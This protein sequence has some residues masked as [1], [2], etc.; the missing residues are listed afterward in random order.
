[1]SP[2]P[3][4]LVSPVTIAVP[5]SAQAVLIDSLIRSRSARGKPSSIITAQVSAAIS[6]API[7]DRSFTVPDT[8]R[9]PISPPGKNGGLTTYESVVITSH[10]SP[11]RNAAPSSIAASPMPPSTGAFASPTNT[12]WISSRIARPPAPCLSITFAS[13]AILNALMIAQVELPAVLMPDPAGALAADHARANGIIG[14][15][16]LAEQPTG[17]RRGDARHD[18]AADAALCEARRRIVPETAHV[19]FESPAR[20]E[21]RPFIAQAQVAVG[22]VRD[23]APSPA[24]RP[25]HLPQHLLRAAV[26]FTRDA[27][28]IHVRNFGP[29]V[30]D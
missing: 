5:A 13:G 29:A 14:H 28:R 4:T 22:N 1:M 12:C 10:S 21:A 8:A 6:V 20:V 25:K 7:I 3:I 16:F 23:S 18:V 15:A 24:H 17:R 9:R 19:D 27:S 26:A 11:T 30:A 2:R